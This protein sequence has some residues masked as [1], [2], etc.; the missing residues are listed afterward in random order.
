[1]SRWAIFTDDFIVKYGIS[2][3]KVVGKNPLPH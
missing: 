1:M 2:F 3:P